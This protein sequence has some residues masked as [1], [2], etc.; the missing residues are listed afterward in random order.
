MK[1]EQHTAFSKILTN[2]ATCGQDLKR[3]YWASLQLS[4][5]QSRQRSK[6]IKRHFRA[7]TTTSRPPHIKILKHHKNYNC[8][9]ILIYC[10]I[11]IWLLLVEDICSLHETGTLNQ[12]PLTQQPTSQC[13]NVLSHVAP[14]AD[15]I[16]GG[17]QLRCCSQDPG[18]GSPFP[19][20][21]ISQRYFLLFRRWPWMTH[22]IEF[23]KVS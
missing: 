20:T 10:E 22:N 4:N 18:H 3:F 6:E 15:E 17:W 14:S 21:T 13:H 9:P 7:C 5:C 2:F 11:T 16:E 19:C 8:C 23:L 1:V 12:R